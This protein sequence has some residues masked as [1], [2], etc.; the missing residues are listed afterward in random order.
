[1]LK[2]LVGIMFSGENEFSSCLAALKAQRYSNWDHFVLENLPNKEAHDELYRRFMAAAGGYQIFLKLDADMVFRDRSGLGQI[3]EYFEQDSELDALMIDVQDWFSGLLI[4]G[5]MTYSKRVVWGENKD[6][7]IVDHHPVPK[8]RALFISR[9]PAPLM[10]HSPDPTPIQAFQFGVH[11]AMKAFQSDR[12]KK[13]VRRAVVQWRILTS[14][15]AQYKT[16]RDVRRLYTLMGVEFVLANS[17]HAFNADYKDV[18][19]VAYF[20]KEV[21][22]QRRDALEKR[23]AYN[24]DHLLANDIRFLDRFSSIERPTT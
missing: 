14:V 16:R 22:P 12:E 8:D 15:W 1:M 24:W 10:D 5:Q 2:A 21:L 3:I 20:E 17:I 13:E 9:P 7:L 19:A 11:R 4:P 18:A 6:K 23:L